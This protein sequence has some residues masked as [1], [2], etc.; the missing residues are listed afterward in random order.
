MVLSRSIT[1]LLHFIFAFK[2]EKPACK[3]IFYLAKAITDVQRGAITYSKRKMFLHCLEF[4]SQREL[5]VCYIA[6]VD[7]LTRQKEE[8]ALFFPQIGV[9]YSK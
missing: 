3:S 9:K 2:V 1:P 6:L 7:F 8:V 4:V 5:F